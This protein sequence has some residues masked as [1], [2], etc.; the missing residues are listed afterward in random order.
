MRTVILLSVGDQFAVQPNGAKTD[1]AGYIAKRI[2]VYPDFIRLLG[3][4]GYSG[5]QK[6]LGV[7]DQY[8]LTFCAP[9]SVLALVRQYQAALQNITREFPSPRTPNTEV[10]R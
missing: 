3:T 2:E 4:Y 7:Y 9:S 6:E 10:V 5:P 8:T 1:N